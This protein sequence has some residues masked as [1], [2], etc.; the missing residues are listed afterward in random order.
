MRK[1]AKAILVAAFL[2]SCAAPKSLPS[3]LD[4]LKTPEELGQASKNAYLAARDA[5]EKSERLKL[6]HQ[7]II[8]AEKCLKNAPETPA[9]LYFQALNT[10]IYIKNHIPNYQK[11][12]HRMVSNCET[13][14]RV[15]PDFE[16]AGCYRILGNI[17]AQ[18]PSFSLNPKNITQDLD[19]SVEFLQEAV[20]LAPNYALNHLFLAKSLVETGQEE[21]AKIELKAFDSL[22]KDGLDQDFPNWK[23]ERDSMA[24]KLL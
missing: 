20:K 14:N 2:S 3:D 17:Y 6:A 15:R 10:G 11:G 16:Q 24:Q 18:A 23:S 9:C 13:L 8:Y 4:Q 5:E 22:P 12:L 19:R 21:Q 1:I 7:G